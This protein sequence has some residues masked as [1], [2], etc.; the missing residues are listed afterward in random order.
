MADRYALIVEDSADIAGMIQM[1]LT[2]MGIESQHA[3]NGFAA[4]KCLE[5]RLPDVLLLDINMPGMSGWQVLDAIKERHPDFS[6]PI[7]VL[8]AL[9][10]P[11]NRLIGKL[12]HHVVRYMTKPFSME[13]LAKNVREVLGLP[14]DGG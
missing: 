1:L 11:A 2:R 5:D 7:I 6:F 4:L 9:A 3:G 8:T 13:E 10:D 12:Q 14:A